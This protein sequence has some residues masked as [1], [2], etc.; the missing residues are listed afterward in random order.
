MP[1][2]FVRRHSS[3]PPAA[4]PRL[5]PPSLSSDDAKRLAELV[6]LRVRYDLAHNDLPASERAA[7]LARITEMEDELRGAGLLRRSQHNP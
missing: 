5:T 1:V 3:P 7:L 2:V 6:H 4:V